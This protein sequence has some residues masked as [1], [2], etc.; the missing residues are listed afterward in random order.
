MFKKSLAVYVIGLIVLMVFMTSALHYYVEVLNR[1]DILKIHEISKDKDIRHVIQATISDETERLISLSKSLKDSEE[2]KVD[3][4]VSSTSDEH[5]GQIRKVVDRLVRELNI[6]VLQVTDQEGRIICNSNDEGVRGELADYSHTTSVLKGGNVLEVSESVRG[7]EIRAIVPAV[8]GRELVGTIMIG[9]LIDDDLAAALAKA[10]D[11]QLTIGTKFSVVASSLPT[12]ERAHL[13]FRV[14]RRSLEEG[15]LI[16]THLP[17]TNMVVNYAPI[18]MAGKPFA[19]VVEFDNSEFMLLQELRKKR[20]F[21][22][23]SGIILASIILGAALTVYLV[24]PLKKLKTK[25]ENTVT[26]ITGREI[27]R[28]TGN[29]VQTLVKSFDVMVESLTAHIDDRRN[30]EE[31]L[32]RSEK[33]YRSLVES[34]EDS[35]YLVDMDYK[36]L[37][38]NREHLARLGL[39]YDSYAGQHY[40]AHHTREETEWFVSKVKLVFETGKSAHYERKSNRD[41]RHFLLTLSPVVGMDGSTEAVTVVSK[42]ISYLKEMEEELRALSLTD[43]LTGLY[44]RRGFLTLADQQIK[45]SRRIEKQILLLFADVDSLKGINDTYGHEEGDMLLI[46]VAELLRESFREFDIIARIGG[47]EFIVLITE[48]GGVDPAL[49]INRLKSDLDVFN[50]RSTREYDLSVSVGIATYDPENPVSMDQL[51]KEADK[52]MYRDKKL[53]DR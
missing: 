1:R 10:T 45:M 20:Y 43:E 24:S 2:L 33:K 51:I 39:P 14:L 47:D 37:Y 28:H 38:M 6:G 50:A 7:W 21:G 46:D 36:Y 29:E 48:Q 4:A 42:D 15:T 53:R 22:I 27:A 52:M 26:K 35:I 30:A 18:T 8:L 16:R 19:L 17:D 44:N 5:V 31:A 13:D 41:G 40:G 23:F 25:A 3:M 9:T 11:V 32:L 34:T 12:M 49:I